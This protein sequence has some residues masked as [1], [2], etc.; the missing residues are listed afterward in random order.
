MPDKSL[1]LVLS[2]DLI[3]HSHLAQ[4]Q[5]DSKSSLIKTH[6]YD[7]PPPPSPALCH[8]WQRCWIS[9]Q[10]FHPVPRLCKATIPHHPALLTRATRTLGVQRA[11]AD[12]A[13]ACDADA[14]WLVRRPKTYA[15]NNNHN[16]IDNDNNFDHILGRHSHKEGAG[17]RGGRPPA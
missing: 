13:L 3:P 9:R 1:R 17:G 2:P 7:P 12:A 5:H 10:F 4:L 16:I 6:A 15:N 11:S 14:R 8:L